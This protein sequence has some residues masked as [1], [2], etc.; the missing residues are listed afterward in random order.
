M[1]GGMRVGSVGPLL[2]LLVGSL[3]SLSCVGAVTKRGQDGYSV[4][5]LGSRDAAQLEVG[6]QAKIEGD[7]DKAIEAFLSVYENRS[8]ESKYR[9]QAL[10]EL[11]QAYSD[12]LNLKK[13][14]KKALFYFKKLIAEFP[15]TG[16]R[17]Q[18]ESRINKIRKLGVVEP[19]E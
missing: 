11:G 19:E 5:F 1:K 17:D 4:T 16:L 9:E 10:Y 12:L 14:Y 8:A 15:A 3:L 2:L 13:D 6:R 18:A 7:Y